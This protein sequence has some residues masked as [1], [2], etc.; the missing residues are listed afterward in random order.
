MAEA[1]LFA[2]SR[3]VLSQHRSGFG[4]LFSPQ[5][6]PRWPGPPGV[7]SLFHSP[8]REPLNGPEQFSPR[9]FSFWLFQ[10]PERRGFTLF[11]QRSSIS[12]RGREPGD[13]GNQSSAYCCLE[14]SGIGVCGTPHLHEF[15]WNYLHVGRFRLQSRPLWRNREER[16]REDLNVAREK[17]AG[18][19]AVSCRRT[20]LHSS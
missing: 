3:G 6:C 16:E 7:C 15:A 5:S 2:G 1:R 10:G 20:P 4:L 19:L 12:T 13:P 11:S 9:F 18:R 17:R 8:S 14:A